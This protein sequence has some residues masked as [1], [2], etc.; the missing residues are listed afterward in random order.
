MSNF[1]GTVS[2]FPTM[3]HLMAVMIACDITQLQGGVGALRQMTGAPATRAYD[4]PGRKGAHPKGSGKGAESYL[5]AWVPKHPGTVEL[6]LRYFLARPGTGA[7]HPDSRW[8][9]PAEGPLAPREAR[10]HG[11]EHL[12]PDGRARVTWPD[13]TFIMQPD[14][15][16][17]TQVWSSNSSPVW[18]EIPR[19]FAVRGPAI[20]RGGGILLQS[21]LQSRRGQQQE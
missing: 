17:Y 6:L 1:A 15:N 13:S 19:I 20:G 14:E 8:M 5:H 21:R 2:R 10:A 16:Y 7:G 12:Q 9:V 4:H 11:D 18:H 3:S